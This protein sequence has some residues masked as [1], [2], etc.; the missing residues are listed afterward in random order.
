VITARRPGAQVCLTALTE[1][2]TGLTIA[3]R[4]PA[5]AQ[6]S[7]LWWAEAPGYSPASACSPFLAWDLWSPL[8]GS[9]LLHWAP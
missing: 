7:V 8:V 1:T 2:R 5:Q 6:G 3:L 9:L 4:D